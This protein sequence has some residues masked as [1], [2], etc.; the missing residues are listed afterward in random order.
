MKKHSYSLTF[1]IVVLILV[2]IGLIS[3]IITFYIN[4]SFNEKVFQIYR[5][6]T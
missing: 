1:K 4:R 2:P 3:A 6:D 5:R